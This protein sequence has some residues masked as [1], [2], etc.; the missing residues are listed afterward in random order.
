MAYTDMTYPDTG[1]DDLWIPQQLE[2]LRWGWGSAYVIYVPGPRI[3]RADRRDGRGS[4]RADSSALLAE[5]IRA[6]YEATPV[7]RQ[8]R[9]NGNED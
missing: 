1:M 3:W 8:E 2:A 6:D 9:E 5:M 4:L 7:P